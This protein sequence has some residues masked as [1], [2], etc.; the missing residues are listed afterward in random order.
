MK[1][2]IPNTLGTFI[3]LS[4]AAKN[5][6]MLKKPP[7]SFP[8][9]HILFNS[10]DSLILI[11]FS[12]FVSSI[13]LLCTHLCVYPHIHP[14]FQPCHCPNHVPFLHQPSYPT[15]I[16]NPERLHCSAEL[17]S[18]QPFVRTRRGRCSWLACLGRRRR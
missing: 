6:P 9:L 11:K 16:F 2:H 4:N 1:C 10:S 8:F 3:K 12:A 5:N 7:L 18:Q 13:A 15:Y 14:H 17:M